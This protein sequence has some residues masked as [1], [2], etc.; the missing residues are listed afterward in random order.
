MLSLLTDGLI[1]IFN[2]YFQIR[3]GMGNVMEV[4][5]QQRLVVGASQSVD[6]GQHTPNVVPIQFTNNTPQPVIYIH[7]PVSSGMQYRGRNPPVDQSPQLSTAEAQMTPASQPQP[8]HQQQPAPQSHQPALS[9]QPYE[10]KRSSPII[11]KDPK[12]GRDVT[13]ILLEK[14]ESKAPANTQANFIQP[15][16]RLVVGAS[17][18]VD[19]GQH[20]PNVVPIQF[21]NNTPQP[22]IYIH[23]PVSSAMQYRG[24]NPP[25]DQSPQL[26]TAEAQMTPAS[27]PQP[28]H[29]QQPAPQSHQ[30]ALSPQQYEKKRSSPIVI[31]DPKSG[32]D[33]TNILLEKKE[34][35]APADTQANFIHAAVV[36]HGQDDCK[37]KE[38]RAQFAQQVAARL[39]PEHPKSVQKDLKSGR[40]VTNILLEKKESKAPVDTQANFIHAAVVPH[41][42]DDC[43]AKEIRAQFAQQVAA[44]L[45]HEHPTSVNQPPLKI[46]ERENEPLVMLHAQAPQSSATKSQLTPTNQSQPAHQQQPAPLSHQPALSRQQYEKKQSSRIVIKDPESGRDITDVM[47]KKKDPF[48]KKRSGRVPGMKRIKAPSTQIQI[49]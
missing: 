35:K 6:S 22:V 25:V 7:Q 16:Q 30:P 32:R 8:T 10:K 28:T 24:Q 26:S 13:D 41:G 42:Q 12:S 27:Q 18:S 47:L 36:P 43:K 38:I 33:V 2:F 3:P 31:K 14:K 9:P 21:T 11:I 29:Q 4:Q 48:Q 5:P 39:L 45:L 40:D 17:Q 1:I 19:S 46:E 49:Y 44:R 34:S 15:Q 20:T 37:A 23:Q